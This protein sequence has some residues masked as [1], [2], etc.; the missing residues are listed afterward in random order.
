MA[1]WLKCLTCKHE[2]LN[3]HLQN[4]MQSGTEASICNPSTPMGR[5]KAEAEEP[6]ASRP[7]C[8]AST[9]VNK[10]DRRMEGEDTDPKVVLWSPNAFY[11]TDIHAQRK[12]KGGNGERERWREG[13]KEKGIEV[14]RKEG[15]KWIKKCKNVAFLKRN[16]LSNTGIQGKSV[17]LF[18]VC[19]RYL[20][21]PSVH[22]FHS[23]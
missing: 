2:D 4:Q 21:P 12:R 6:E 7:V 5:Q 20:A 23:T 1:P 11:G 10:Q 16:N 8:L 9:A 3:L 18:M 15:R 13:G 17:S 19:L 14:G 22:C